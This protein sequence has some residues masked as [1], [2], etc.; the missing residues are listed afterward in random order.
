MLCEHRV[1]SYIY[2]TMLHK[3]IRK[4]GRHRRFKGLCREMFKPRSNIL[5]ICTVQ[6]TSYTSVDYFI[7]IYVEYPRERIRGGM[8][9]EHFQT[10]NNK[11]E[12]NSCKNIGYFFIFQH[13]Y[14]ICLHRF[15]GPFNRGLVRSVPINCSVEST[16][17]N[18]LK[19]HHHKMGKNHF[20]ITLLNF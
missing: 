12:K 14:H 5:Y 3:L 15:V 20:T 9:R 10:N 19:G 1:G 18:I 13:N 8:S 16:A 11:I 4:V 17:S 6:Y 7:H 2:Y